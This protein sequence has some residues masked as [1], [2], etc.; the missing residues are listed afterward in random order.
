MAPNR[1]V[2]QNRLGPGSGMVTPGNHPGGMAGFMKEFGPKLEGSM[3]PEGI[4]PPDYFSN[5]DPLGLKEHGQFGD[6]PSDQQINTQMDST[7]AP[8]AGETPG[9]V[10]RPDIQDGLPDIISASGPMGKQ[11]YTA[12]PG[13]LD[14]SIGPPA[15]DPE[16]FEPGIFRDGARQKYT[17]PPELLEPLGAKWEPEPLM[18]L[19]GPN[20]TVRVDPNTIKPGPRY[21][22]RADNKMPLPGPN[23]TVRVDPSTIGPGP[24]FPGSGQR[25]PGMAGLTGGEPIM[26]T[27]AFD[28]DME[29]KAQGG[30][31]IWTRDDAPVNRGAGAQSMSPEAM[32]RVDDAANKGILRNPETGKVIKPFARLGDDSA[33]GRVFTATSGP[34]PG[35]AASDNA[36]LGGPKPF[37]RLGSDLAPEGSGMYGPQGKL[38]LPQKTQDKLAA[39]NPRAAA[40]AEAKI[41]ANANRQMGQGKFGVLGQ[42]GF[43]KNQIQQIRG[44]SIKAANAKAAAASAQGG[45]NNR[46]ATMA[47]VIARSRNAMRNGFRGGGNRGGGQGGG[48]GQP[49]I[50]GQTLP[51]FNAAGTPNST[52]NN[53]AY[54]NDLDQQR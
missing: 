46:P 30:S 43:D 18:P 37:A 14:V 32:A 24:R 20:G 54:Q 39:M 38:I 33:G 34:R 21:P 16:L 31:G 5:P 23:G 8:A 36:R 44:D 10:I 13:S 2:L 53:D 48:E 51:T 22:G 50:T 52:F 27:G 15:A 17:A 7:L 42:M 40:G 4:K 3:A 47:E 35:A 41:R 11:K 26:N 29:H 25:G 1:D 45:G 28:G 19:P 49:D 6:S 12:P 9:P